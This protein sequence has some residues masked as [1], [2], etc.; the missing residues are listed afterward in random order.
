MNKLGNSVKF[1]TM[2]RTISKLYDKWGYSEFVSKIE[3]IDAVK[4]ILLLY[5]NPS[6]ENELIEFEELRSS[7]YYYY[8]LLSNAHTHLCREF[9]KILMASRIKRYFKK[10]ISDPSR[11][12]CRDRLMREFYLDPLISR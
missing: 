11:K 2:A 6:L 8:I 10:A 9:R 7:Y 5:P 1:D 3:L 12:M 4:E